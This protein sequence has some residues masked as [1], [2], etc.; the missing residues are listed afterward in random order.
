MGAINSEPEINSRDNGP[1]FSSV[2]L[3]LECSDSNT[4]NKPQ[5]ENCPQI[6]DLKQEASISGQIKAGK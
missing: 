2:T 3:S 4:T 5:A 6:H 1:Y